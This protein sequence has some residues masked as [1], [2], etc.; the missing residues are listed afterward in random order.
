M[1]AR[2]QGAFL[3]E[4]YR[5]TCLQ[6]LPRTESTPRTS[7]ICPG[8][9]STEWTLRKNGGKQKTVCQLRFAHWSPSIGRLQ[10]LT[11]L[12]FTIWK[13]FQDRVDSQKRGCTKIPCVEFLSP[14]GYLLQEGYDFHIPRVYT[15][16]ALP[17]LSGLSQ[18]GLQTDT[19]VCR[20]PFAH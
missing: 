2:V 20:V 10:C 5:G 17:G 16:K 14:T 13:L 3:S 15:L 18:K 9:P 6:D 19:A 4:A 1:Q 7:G 8:L 12:A 11:F